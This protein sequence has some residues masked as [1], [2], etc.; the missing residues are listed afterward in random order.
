MMSVVRVGYHHAFL[1]LIRCGESVSDVVLCV[2]FM[3]NV[4]VES[5]L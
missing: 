4:S 3:F 5:G 2:C 1:C